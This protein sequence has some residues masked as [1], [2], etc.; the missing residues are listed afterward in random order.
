MNSVPT[1][2]SMASPLVHLTARSGIR[3]QG[4]GHRPS[5]EPP[6]VGDAYPVGMTDPVP[7]PDD[8][9]I[10]A[11]VRGHVQGVFFRDTTVRRAHALGL[12]GWV[13]NRP[14]G[15]VEVHAEGPADAVE[16]LV[17]FLNVGPPAAL[18]EAVEVEF[19]KPEGHEQF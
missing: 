5:R 9:A 14:D 12:R 1:G 3:C 10:R 2:V 7:G 6:Q 4:R 13:R 16:R 17:D 8:T 19:C 15:A 11:V 18:V